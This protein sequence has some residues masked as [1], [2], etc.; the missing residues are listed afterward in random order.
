MLEMKDRKP[1]D[2]AEGCRHRAQE[3]RA[4]AVGELNERMRTRLESSAD[5]WT[6]RAKLLQRLQS[7]RTATSA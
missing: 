6:A 3:N 1:E 2:T 4:Q 5:A 7:G